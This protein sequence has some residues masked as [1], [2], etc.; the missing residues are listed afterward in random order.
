M[1]NKFHLYLIYNQSLA[2]SKQACSAKELDLP[3]P[4][5]PFGRVEI[6]DEPLTS[7]PEEDYDSSVFVL[8]LVEEVSTNQEIIG[9]EIMVC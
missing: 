6:I 9:E 8:P 4:I 7:D 5:G 3:K 1:P 2:Y